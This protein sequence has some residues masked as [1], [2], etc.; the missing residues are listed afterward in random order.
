MSK[1]NIQQLPKDKEFLKCFTAPP[2]HKLIYSDINSLEP[3]VLAHFSKDPGLMDLYGPNAKP[4]D[5]YLYVGSK[6][7]KW[8]DKILQ[9][10]DPDN[11][12]AESIAKA[13]KFAKDERT[14][15]KPAYLGWMYGLG[16]STMHESTNIP[17]EECKDILLN[18]DNAFPGV[19]EFNQRLKEEWTLNGG[20]VK[21]EWIIDP[22]TGRNIPKFIDGRPGWI[23][24]GRNR[25]IGV[26][27]DKI[28]DL[29]NRFVQSTGHDV[30]LQMLLFINKN[31]TITMKPYNVDMHDATI[32]Q[33]R[34]YE[35]EKAVQVFKNSYNE[36]N[37]TL[38]WDVRI[39][40][41][42]E[43]GTTLADFV[44]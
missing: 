20:W 2:G 7:G 40:G 29:G 5:V 17:I 6:I 31:R 34:E 38:G 16:A 37:A 21:Q 8:K 44:E 18:I 13:K 33:V 42:I 1:L 41:D 36:L 4:N 15:V 10:Y 35:V 28:K 19:V 39:S 12:T 3:H 24:N 23:Y 11:P 30:L 43:I 14:A 25:P 27:P 32:W 26:A 9:H 22:H